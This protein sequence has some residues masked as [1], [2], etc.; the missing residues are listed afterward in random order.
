MVRKKFGKAKQSTNAYNCFI[1]AFLSAS[2]K[3][4]FE[5][6]IETNFSNLLINVFDSSLFG[7]SIALSRILVTSGSP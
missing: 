5:L 2:L 3:G 4:I 1:D 7:S 6:P